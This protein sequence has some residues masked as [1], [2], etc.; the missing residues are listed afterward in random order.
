MGC[1]I[2]RPGCAT[3]CTSSSP[4]GT[5]PGVAGAKRAMTTDLALRDL[6]AEM[7]AELTGN[8]LPFWM[9]VARDR[10]HGGVVG[11][12]DEDGTPHP[13]APKGVILHARVL[14]TFSAAY[15]R[16]GEESLR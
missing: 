14:W 5:S 12:I 9:K 3:C 7:H 16:L 8:I 4:I 10:R 11:L 1:A 6:K 13:D 2:P 15:R